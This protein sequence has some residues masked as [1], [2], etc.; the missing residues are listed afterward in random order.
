MRVYLSKTDVATDAGA[1]LLQLCLRITDDGKIDLEEIKS[2]IRWLRVNWKNESIPAIPYLYDI[3]K[4][5]TADRVI[6]KDEL[7]ELQIAIERVIPTVQRTPAIQE[8]ERNAKRSDENA[9]ANSDASNANARK[10]RRNGF[11]RKNSAAGSD[12]AAKAADPAV[13]ARAIAP[14]VPR[15][16]S[17]PRCPPKALGREAGDCLPPRSRL[18]FCLQ[19]FCLSS[20][21][22]K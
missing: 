16:T 19:Y 4:R 6:D 18:F 8:R 7:L 10:P 13:A 3:M 9:A 11:A 22:V 2:L 1:E 5:I 15:A 12:V 17:K 14:N 20:S 21:L